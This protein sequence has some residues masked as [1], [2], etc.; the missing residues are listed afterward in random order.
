MLP[1]I[2][3][4]LAFGQASVDSNGQ[5]NF[6][7][8]SEIPGGSYLHQGP[9]GATDSSSIFLPSGAQIPGGEHLHHHHGQ[10]QPEL[11]GPV[12]TL[13]CV[14]ASSVS[15]VNVVHPNDINAGGKKSKHGGG[16]NACGKNKKF[17][18]Q[19]AQHHTMQVKTPRL[20]ML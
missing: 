10:L 14:E 13:E 12:G 18:Q 16:G 17:Q 6:S 11:P 5:I 9:G 4:Y 3:L 7:S 1:V 20:D 8:T 15:S 19:M 2:F